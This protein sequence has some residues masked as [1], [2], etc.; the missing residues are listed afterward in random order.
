MCPITIHIIL[1]RVKGVKDQGWYPEKSASFMEDR[2]TCNFVETPANIE[3]KNVCKIEFIVESSA[4]WMCEH[5][6]DMHVYQ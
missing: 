4:V 2:K 1:H 3:T 6:K 5:Q